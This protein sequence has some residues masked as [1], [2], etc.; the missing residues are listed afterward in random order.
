[1]KLSESEEKFNTELFR[2]IWK[3]QGSSVQKSL[4]TFFYKTTWKP[5]ATWHGERFT[6]QL[7]VTQCNLNS[8]T[9]MIQQKSKE[10]HLVAYENI[11]SIEREHNSLYCITQLA[12]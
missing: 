11:F 5:E 1:M 9:R 12:I 2:K 3:V 7:P 4:E 8:D 6:R 10:Q